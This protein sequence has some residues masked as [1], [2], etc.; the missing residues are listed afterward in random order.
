MS[1]VARFTHDGILD[2]AAEIVLLKGSAL[3]IGDVADRLGAPSG[4]IYHR[5]PS[6]DELLV[7]LWL[8]SVH[9]FHEDYL[10]AGEHPDPEQAIVDMALCVATFTRRH[11]AEAA[12]MT[13]FRQ[14]R[15]V[16][17]APEACQEE[18]RTVNDGVRS[19]HRRLAFAR[20]GSRAQRYLTLVRVA[21]IESPYGLVR[22]YVWE[23][24]PSWMDPVIESSSRAILALGD[25]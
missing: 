12:A 11:R 5:F 21:A 18:V 16:E 14:S 22:P 8:R 17:T 6:R 25:G 24:V 4:S 9:R 13:L 23:R 20:Y 10:E 19:R 1:P 15:L 3:T 2:A 7:R